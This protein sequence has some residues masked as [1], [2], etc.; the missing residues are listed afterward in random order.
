MT[1]DIDVIKE[2]LWLKARAVEGYDPD[3]F[4]K[5]A[6]GAWIRKDMFGQP[7]NMF[8]WGIDFIFPKVLGGTPVESN[9]RALNCRNLASKGNDYPS[10]NAVLIA[11]GNRNVSTDIYVTINSKLRQILKTIYEN[12]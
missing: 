10:Y 11:D 1:P 8:G 5:D 12:A 2:T 3:I 4:R 7:D 9:L 6:C